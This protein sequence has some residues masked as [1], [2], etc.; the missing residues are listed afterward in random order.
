MYEIIVDTG[1]TFTDAILIDDERRISMAKFPTN[2]ANPSAS[3]MGDVKRFAEQRNCT[4]QE[5][6]RNTNT[7]VIGTTLPTN[8]IVE[9]KGAKCCLLYTKGF[10]D[11]PELGRRLPKDEIYNFRLPEPEF[12]IPRYLRF[13]VEERVNFY[14]GVVTPLNEGDVLEAIKK[15]KEN[16]VEVAV[17]CFLHSYINPEHEE[18]A[19]EIIKKE[20]PN[21]VLSSHILRRFFEWDRLSTAALAGAVKPVMS[22]FIANLDDE[23]RK[24]G[25]KGTCLFTT[26]LGGVASPELCLDNPA[27]VIG[28]GPASGPLLGRFL[29]KL[30]NFENV[31][32]I[33][34]GGTTFDISMLPGGTI[35]VTPEMRVGDFV[36]ALESVD[37][38]SIGAGGGSIAWLD[39]RNM[40]QVGPAS[41][42]ADPGPACYG[43][44]GQVPTVTDADVVLGYI[45][46]DFF[47]GGLMTLDID[48]AKKTIEK[49][50][51]KP[52]NLDIVAAAYTIAALVEDNMA[53]GIFLGAVQRGLDPRE[54][55]LVVGGG[56]GPVHAAAIASRLGISQI[57]VPRQAAAFCALGASLA[58]YEYV[59]NHCIYR[60]EDQL[61][62]DE[63]KAWFHALEEAGMDALTRQG[64][65]KENVR[66]A[67]GAEMRYFGQLRDIVIFLP[68]I[69]SGEPF[70]EQTLKDLIREFHAR[71]QAIYGWSDPGMAVAIATLKLRAVGTRRPVDLIKQPLSSKDVSA[72]LK[73]K[74]Q[75]YFNG[76]GVSTP[77]YDTSRLN[78]GNVIAGPAILEDSTTTVVVPNGAQLTV[79]EYCNY[80]IRL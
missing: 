52:L 14:G 19:G 37:V 46:A 20:Y 55:T 12:S 63:L 78:P 58:N 38:T 44:G 64:Q 10:R 5:L 34:M 28:S 24:N 60:T 77:C 3:I 39:D 29:A 42:G 7:I 54:F 8:T 71:H 6:L 65:T 66:L 50:I 75:V 51:A 61:N 26:C 57:Y 13:G 56:A 45:P 79:D 2:H 53:Q 69:R 25:F 40:V 16:D 62:I 17:V 47:L 15:A 35:N 80:I 22:R 30:N 18:K 1:G 67:R 36:N 32:V 33:D 73:R 72:A 27:L 31:I 48:L 23:F 21:V 76:H 68:E 59:L 11:I 49:N 41:A 70:T 9:K 43:K 74:R 4:I